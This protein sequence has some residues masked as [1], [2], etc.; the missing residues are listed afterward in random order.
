[1]QHKLSLIAYNRGLQLYRLGIGVAAPFNAKAKL[2]VNGRKAQIPVIE[3]KAGEKV[4]WVHCASLGEFEQARPVIEELKAGYKHVKIV[5]SFFSPS[6]YEIRKNYQ[7][8]D[9]VLYLPLDTKANAEQFIHNLKPDLALFVKYEFWHHYLHTLKAHAI[10]I[11]LFSAIFRKQQIFFKPYGG[12]YRSMLETFGKIYVQNEE[13]KQLLSTINIHTEVAN[14]TRFDR[15]IAIA[16]NHNRYPLIEEFKQ[17]K[18]LLVAGS[19]WAKDEA[20]IASAIK[21]N[22][23]ANYKYI[24]APHNI[25]TVEIDALLK[26]LPNAVK[27][28]DLTEQNAATAQTIIIDNIGYLAHIYA[29][30]DIVYVGGGFNTSVHNVLEPAVYGVPILFGPNHTKANEAIELQH[31]GAAFAVTNNEKLIQILKW[32][33]EDNGKQKAAAGSAA[34]TYVYAKQGGTQQIMAYL[35]QLV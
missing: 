24:I 23:L 4:V 1:M 28:S 35:K 3:K 21:Q 33:T 10:P 6:G 17:D 2:W 5:L 8:A 14:D 19:T 7:H 25:H 32:L 20:L 26:Q 29:Y 27:W 18:K 15:V 34:K 12:L 9:L 13:S 11:V 16:E 30:A 22:I 31:N